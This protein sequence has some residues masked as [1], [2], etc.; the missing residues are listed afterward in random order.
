MRTE[1]EIFLKKRI[2]AVFM[3]VFLLIS[4]VGCAKSD[5]SSSAASAGG[6]AASSSAADGES[7]GAWTVYD[8]GGV[9]IALPTQYIGQLTIQANAQPVDP[10]QNGSTLLS[11]SETASLEQSRADWGQDSGAGFLF[12]IQLLTEPE[13]EQYFAQDNSGRTVFATDGTNYYAYLTATDV[14][15]YRSGGQIDTQSDDWKTWE[16]LC[17]IGPQVQTDMISRNGLTP[18]SDD[19]VL[20]RDFTWDSSHA[21]LKYYSYF[22]SEKDRS[23]YDQL[24]LSQPAKQGDGGI[25]CV[26][27]WYDEY[28]NRYLYT[29]SFET[30]GGEMLARD[31]YAKLQKECDSGKRT[32]LLT[33]TGAAIDFVKNCGYFSDTPTE[34]SFAAEDALDTAYAELNNRAQ[35][36]VL[37]LLSGKGVSDETLLACAGDFTSDTWGFLGRCEYGSDWWTALD[38]ALQKAAVGDGQKD[39]DQSLL[40]LFLSYPKSDGS[41]AKGLSQILRQQK[42]ADA[43]VF[44]Q[45]LSALPAADQ[46]SV[47][48]ALQ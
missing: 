31:Y 11:V 35:Q 28:G 34:D 22:S 18:C 20:S 2:V 32:D 42:K 1:G 25:W 27:R 17:E 13:Y 5:G 23:Q 33:P 9:K 45:V 8:C 14:Q 43:S 7:D 16:K 6:S 36:I 47:K 19:T 10:D 38:T 39:R 40:H 3:A 24:V 48:A 29:P 21:Y 4:T 37:D 26:E 12:S 44:G 41:I 15:F 46:A 30:M